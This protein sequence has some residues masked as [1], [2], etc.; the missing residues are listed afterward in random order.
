[1]IYLLS[2][3]AAV[4]FVAHVGLLI[5]SFARGHFYTTRY[6]YSHVTLWVTGL[7]IFLLALLFQGKNVSGFLDY[8]DTPVRKGMIL[9]GT[10]CL[11]L[12][13]HV[14]VR[15]LVLPAYTAKKS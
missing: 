11:S 5:A 2:I 9:V 13:A 7:L 12:I 8:F 3:A 15:T 4:F 6:V 14:I 1:M 10:V